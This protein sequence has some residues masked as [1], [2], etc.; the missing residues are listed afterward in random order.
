MGKVITDTFL[1]GGLDA[2]QGATRMTVQPSEPASI[3]NITANKLAE[4]TSKTSGAFPKA[5]GDTSGRK[6]D[7]AADSDV[8][9]DSSGTAT[10]VCYDDGTDWFCTTC[11][12]QALTSGGTVTV[13]TWDWE[14]ADPT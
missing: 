12:S 14:V 7:V 10:H 3:A 5:N 9:I 1:D 8:S 13:P 4:V 11:T 2:M 6:I